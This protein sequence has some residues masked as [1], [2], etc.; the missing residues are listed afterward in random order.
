MDTE[1]RRVVYLEKNN[2]A[3]YPL[4]YPEDQMD[5][6]PTLYG[7]YYREEVR[8]HAELRF[9]AEFAL[10]AEAELV[11]ELFQRDTKR[12]GLEEALGFARIHE[13]LISGTT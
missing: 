6:E 7:I 9:V 10:Q 8:G 2:T 3:S 4:D 5:G 12:H 1:I 13:N 11:A